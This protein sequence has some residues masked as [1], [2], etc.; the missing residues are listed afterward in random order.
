MQTGDGAGA[1][2]SI[3]YNDDWGPTLPPED[4]KPSP[5]HSF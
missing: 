3:I 2:P 1:T 4:H 5:I